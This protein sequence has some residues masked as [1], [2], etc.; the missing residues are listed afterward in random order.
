MPRTHKLFHHDAY[1][2]NGNLQI[3]LPLFLNNQVNLNVR[4]NIFSNGFSRIFEAEFL[5]V[6]VN[7]MSETD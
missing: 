3:F 2:N 5:V 1:R 7:I 6:L 4:K